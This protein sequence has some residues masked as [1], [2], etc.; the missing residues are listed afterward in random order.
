MIDNLFNALAGTAIGMVYVCMKRVYKIIKNVID[1][2][3][4]IQ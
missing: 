2:G 3:K 4:N 1:I